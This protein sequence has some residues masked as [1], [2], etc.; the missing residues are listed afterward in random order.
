MSEITGAIGHLM[1]AHVA[2]TSAGFVAVDLYDGCLIYDFERRQLSLID[3]DM[4]RPGPYLLDA[5]R[6][7]GS[8]TFMAPEEW[9]RGAT[10]DQRTT[11]FTLGRFAFV[12]L[13]AARRDLPDRDRFRGDDRLYEIAARACATDP[14]DRFPSVADLYREWTEATQA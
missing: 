7:Y 3:L 4:Y 6:Q 9:K 13:G 10:I 11:V 2:V 1:H 14:A 12:L 5:D 8:T